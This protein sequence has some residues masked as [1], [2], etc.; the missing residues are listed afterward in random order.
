MEKITTFLKSCPLDKSP[1][2]QCFYALWDRNRDDNFVKA[3][4]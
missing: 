3:R 4:G 2:W 1:L